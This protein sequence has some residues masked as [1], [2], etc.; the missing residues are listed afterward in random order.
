MEMLDRTMF[1]VRGAFC[2]QGKRDAISRPI[3]SG[4]PSIIFIF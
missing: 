1:S 4:Y 3:V 2:N